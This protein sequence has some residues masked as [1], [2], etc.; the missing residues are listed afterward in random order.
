M[1]DPLSV[2]AGII[3]ILGMTDMVVQYGLD[4]A[5]ATKEIQELKEKFEALGSVLRRLMERCENAEKS[6]PDEPSPWLRGL[7]EVRGRRFDKNGVWVFEYRGVV[8]Q[9]KQAIEEAVAG[10]NPSREW[11]KVEAY[12]R[13]IWHYKKD[14][15]TEILTTVSTCFATVNTI[16]ALK[17]DE[18]LSETL[19]LVKENNEYS[20]S[21]LASIDDRMSAIEVNQRREEERGRKEAEQIERLEIADWLSPLSFIAKQDELWTN[22][23]KEV[24]EW[25]WQ[26][27]SFHAWTE[28]RPWYLQCVGAPGVGKTVLSSILTHHLPS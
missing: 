19:N 22:C 15:F 23:F 4:F 28:G 7:W 18:T 11:K 21:K 26:D 3:A 13:A 12:Q 8:A 1:T 25:L 17:N 6:D 5:R 16:L 20:I 14:T 24:G 10:L 9:L 2:S 27:E